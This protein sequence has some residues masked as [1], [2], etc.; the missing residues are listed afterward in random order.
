MVV[1]FARLYITIILLFACG[2]GRLS[3][4]A[5]SDAYIVAECDGG[6]ANRLRALAAYLFLAERKYNGS[7]TTFIWEKNSACPGH[8]LSLF[9]PVPRLIFATNSSRAIVNKHALVVYNNTASHFNSIVSEEYN[10]SFAGMYEDIHRRYFHPT[11]EIVS[12][13]SAFV[14]SHNMCNMSAIHL[15]TTDLD[16][17]LPP[18]KRTNFR[19]AYKFIDN[20]PEGE[21]V[22][23]L[24]DSPKTQQH[25]IEKYGDK[26]LVYQMIKNETE[27]GTGE[28]MYVLLC[29]F[30]FVTPLLYLH[31]PPY[32]R[33]APGP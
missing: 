15:R 32:C 27:W 18:R 16:A 8:F 33:F 25:M 14:K 5:S 22:F 7:H 2:D 4:S 12:K 3:T 13:V 31:K 17:I 20:R 11:R 21:K 29:T 23:L 1:V 30:S 19:I 10:E 28:L 26:I 6:L 24:T 9:D